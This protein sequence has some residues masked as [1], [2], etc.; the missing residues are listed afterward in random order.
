MHLNLV[1]GQQRL[2][3]FKGNFY[4]KKMSEKHNVQFS[5]FRCSRG[6]KSFKALDTQ[7]TIAA[8]DT[9]LRRN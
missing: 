5:F 9:R 6:L 3:A 7:M 4:L 8:A 2:F 1:F